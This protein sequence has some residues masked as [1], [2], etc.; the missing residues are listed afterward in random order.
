MDGLFD[1]HDFSEAVTE[2]QQAPA[3]DGGVAPDTPTKRSSRG[4]GRGSGSGKLSA[5]D[6]QQKWCVGCKAICEDVSGT[7]R[8]CK[9]HQKMVWTIEKAVAR[10]NQT[11]LWGDIV[12]NDEHTFEFLLKW[13]R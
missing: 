4:D 2:E 1:L 8:F 10:E 12:N 13:A 11:S 5:K 3:K 6:V 7:K 9:K